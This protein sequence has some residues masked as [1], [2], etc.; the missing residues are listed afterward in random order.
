MPLKKI[1]RVIYSLFGVVYV[2]IGA[3]A[4][5]LPAG[6]LPQ[7]LTDDFLA[8]VIPSPFLEHLLQEFG[9]VVLALGFVFLW[10]AKRNEHSRSFHWAMTFYFSLSALIHWIGPEGPIGSWQRGI[11][12]SI[13]PAIMLLLGLLQQRERMRVSSA[14]EQPEVR[15]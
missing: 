1:T 12:N 13:P 14:A 7:S 4:M 3:G 5:L 15:R 11:A 6:W 2:L 9:T 8:E 10:Y